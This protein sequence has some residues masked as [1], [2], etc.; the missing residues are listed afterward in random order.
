MQRHAVSTV[1][2][3]T[4]GVFR[5]KPGAFV[6]AAALAAFAISLCL[7][8]PH[9]A[10]AD[11]GQ[12]IHLTGSNETLEP[13]LGLLCPQGGSAE[14]EF[15]NE[16]TGQISAIYDPK[17]RAIAEKACQ[18]SLGASG[19]GNVDI[20]N[21]SG[22][23]ILVGFAPQAGSQITWGA[24]CGTPIQGT[25]VKIGVGGSCHAAVTDSVANPGSRFCA[26][27]LDVAS[28]G[29]LNCW[30]A[31]AQNRTLIETYFEPAP[32]FGAG[33]PNCIWYD[34]SVI[35]SNCTDQAWASDR[36]ANTGGA[37]YNVPARLSCAAEPTYVCKG[38][39]SSKYG[40][41]NY[42]SNCGNPAARPVSGPTP[43]PSALNAYFYPDDNSY[44]QPNAVCPNGQTLTIT[45][46][47]G[48]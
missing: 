11:E 13:D 1:A 42:P 36:C 27:T 47:S 21:S 29:A 17:L 19:S 24:G 41:A 10:A 48:S 18:P 44:G 22:K 45:F 33:T 2:R 15:E 32:C 7:V 35:P 43:E 12:I 6:R 3:S 5:A 8:H 20:V 25:T 14:P 38:P 40:S 46:L 9:P 30:A 26:A 37:A 28:S 23:V 34:I 16:T 31:Q 39:A 4:A